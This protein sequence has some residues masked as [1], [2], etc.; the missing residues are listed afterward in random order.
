MGLERQTIAGL[1][2]TAA[3][4]ILTQT[5]A[6]GATLL[7]I[8]LL[9]PADYGL[10]ALSAV[11]ISIC[12]GV[13]ELGLGA[14][15]IQARTLTRTEIA[16]VGGALVVLNGATFGMVC[17][18]APLLAQAFRQPELALVVQVSASQFL[19]GAVASI[20]EASAYRD[21]RF[22]FLAG[23]DIAS[24]LATSAMTVLLALS[25]A[26]V[27]ALVLGNLLGYVSRTA[28]LLYAGPFVRPS[29]SL[30]GIGQLVR[31]G[32]AWSAARFAWQLTYQADVLIA[33]RFLAQ[34]A[35]GIYSVAVHLANLPVQ[36][37]MSIINPVAFPAIARL[38]HDLPLM[39]Q[40]MLGAIRM[41]GLGA[42][43][44]LWGL[45]AVVPEFVNVVLGSQ[46]RSVILPFQLIAI[47]APLRMIST[48]CA[49]AVSALGRA[50]IELA[51]TLTSLVVFV[52]AMLVGVHWNFDGL[53]IAYVV[54]VSVSFLLN[55]PR[56]ARVVGL[57][58]VEI[59]SQY[60]EHQQPLELLWWLLLAA[61]VLRCKGYRSGC[62]WRH[63]SRSALQR[64]SAHFP[65][66]TEAFGRT[67]ER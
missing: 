15:L 54:A 10:M 58:L 1:K 8:R 27:W 21:M 22:R 34:E 35:V 4:K 42:I 57:S 5:I 16:R 6:W 39:R 12:G 23:T 49:T 36:K 32:G 33:G 11:V 14:A 62:G 56:T 65:Y 20:P 40:R 17:L 24:G 18:V 13:A 38:Q 55:F 7:V 61:G 29:F 52:A 26:G 50:D 53:A 47:V 37:A 31:F 41:L 19:L 44:A 25:G 45:S 64:T 51:N 48:L 60:V 66:L 2:W 46:W 63:L 28:I 43:P 67:L 59:S 3:A 9:V 30:R